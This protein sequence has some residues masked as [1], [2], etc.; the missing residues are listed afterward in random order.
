MSARTFSLFFVVLIAGSLAW[1][2][3]FAQEFDDP[4]RPP[5][6]YL[7]PSVAVVA[8]AAASGVSSIKIGPGKRRSAIVHGKTAVV[9]ESIGDAVLVGISELGVILRHRDGT[10]ERLYIYD[11]IEKRTLPVVGS[12]AGG[13]MR[14]R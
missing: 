2:S 5:A 3:V 8:S 10:F 1:Q 9:G 6:A 12:G 11:S 13:E 14:G 4:T 7:D